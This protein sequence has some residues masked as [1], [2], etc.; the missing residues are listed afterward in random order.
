MPIKYAVRS[1]RETPLT[2]AEQFEGKEN[3][4]SSLELC[5]SY[6]D[7]P[8][9]VAEMDKTNGVY[10]LFS[11]AGMK[12][13]AWLPVEKPSEVQEAYIAGRSRQGAFMCDSI[14]QPLLPGDYLFTH[15]NNHRSL[16][17][18]QLA[19]TMR[20]NIVVESLMDASS[21]KRLATRNPYSFLRVPKELLEG[22]EVTPEI[23]TKKYAVL[24][25]GAEIAYNRLGNYHLTDELTARE[26][27]LG[28]FG[29][30]N[31][32]EEITSGWIPFKTSAYE[33]K[34]LNSKVHAQKKVVDSLPVPLTDAMGTDILLGD[35]VFSNDNHYNDFMLCEVIGFTKERVRLVGYDYKG[36]RSLRGMRIVTLNWPK[37]VL[38]LPLIMS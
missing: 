21:T 6:E 7:V 36:G 35:F 8:P 17:L 18:F 5:Y 32:R 26:A 24:E 10:A 22:G 28:F 27:E 37:N 33:E 11:E 29:Y 13:S 3:G 38:K 1:K 34:L 12:L 14:G 16:E 23:W 19:R 4:Y 9:I 20:S 30:F 15:S 31:S 25:K 2:R